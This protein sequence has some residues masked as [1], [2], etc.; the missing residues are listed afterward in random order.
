MEFEGSGIYKMDLKGKNK[1]FVKKD[2]FGKLGFSGK[3]IYYY[4][5]AYDTG[6]VECFN[7]NTGK[8]ENNV[9]LS[10]LY[11]PA[12]KTKVTYNTKE[13]KAGK[14]ENGKWKYKTVFKGNENVEDA[15]V[16]GGKI[17]IKANYYDEAKG[18]GFIKFYIMD[19]NGKNKKIL[20]EGEA[21]G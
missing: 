20:H 16:C 15:C 12:S 14:Y 5:R 3:N 7:L 17:L 8:P 10:Y 11:D 4:N 9:I 13:V 21:V 6:K 1:K 2:V 18:R 19:L